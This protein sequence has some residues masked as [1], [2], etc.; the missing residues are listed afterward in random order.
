MKSFFLG[1]PER[2]PAWQLLTKSWP[3]KNVWTYVM[4]ISSAIVFPLSSEFCLK[5]ESQSADWIKVFV[6][7]ARKAGV[8]FTF[9]KWGR[10]SSLFRATKST[11]L[12]VVFSSTPRN[13]LFVRFSSLPFSRASYFLTT[14]PSFTT[15][16]IT[17][18][19]YSASLAPRRPRIH[20]FCFWPQL[21]LLLQARTRKMWLR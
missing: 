19:V 7:Q 3:F 4:V 10:S 11:W 9:N 8:S 16:D 15:R 12:I 21:P 2:L 20:R 18:M 17:A 13:R 5:Y 6:A 14:Y 1:L